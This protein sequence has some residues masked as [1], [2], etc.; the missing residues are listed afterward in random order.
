MKFTVMQLKNIRDVDYA[1]MDYEFARKH[2]FK[3][4]DY[5]EVYHS[6]MYVDDGETTEHFLDSV[7]TTFNIFRP[8]DF[9]GHSMS[10]SDIIKLEDGRVF[11]VDS[12]G[13]AEV[14]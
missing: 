14:K 9:N 6:E 1:F 3:L 11:Y 12:I 7:F 4:K 10:V 2:D 13:Y 5:K 8:D